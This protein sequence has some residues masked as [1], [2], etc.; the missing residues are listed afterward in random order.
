MTLARDSDDQPGL[1]LWARAVTVKVCLFLWVAS[2]LC[3]TP[4]DPRDWPRG[5]GGYE[6]DASQGPRRA[7]GLRVAPPPVRSCGGI[8]GS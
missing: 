2:S 5:V 6:R 3:R 1:S 4:F 8:F 7:S